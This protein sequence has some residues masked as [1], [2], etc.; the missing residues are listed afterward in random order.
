MRIFEDEDRA[1]RRAAATPRGGGVGRAQARA[2]ARGSAART[3]L[4]PPPDEAGREEGVHRVRGRTPIL[5]IRSYV[6]FKEAP[7]P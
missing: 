3:S 4:P 2:A 1:G 6:L 7:I 5:G